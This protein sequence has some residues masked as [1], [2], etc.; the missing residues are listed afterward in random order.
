MTARKPK[1]DESAETSSSIENTEE[2]REMMHAKV[3]A[4]IEALEQ[5]KQ[6]NAGLNLRI[7]ATNFAVDLVKRSRPIGEHAETMS[8]DIIKAAQ[9]IEKYLKGEW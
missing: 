9:N 8:F 1:S 4:L 3:N 6:Y 7:T 2:E 5:E